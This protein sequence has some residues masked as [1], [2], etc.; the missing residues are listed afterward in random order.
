MLNMFVCQ[1][2]R[3][4]SV[5][6]S[7][8]FQ[9]PFVFFYGFLCAVFCLYGM[10]SGHFYIMK[11]IREYMVEHSASR[12]PVHDLMK[13]AVESYHLCTLRFLYM[14]FGQKDHF[15]Q[16]CQFFFFDIFRSFSCRQTFQSCPHMIDVFH[17]FPGDADYFGTSVRCDLHQTFQIQLPQGLP[18]RCPADT[19][20]FSQGR[21]FQF[22]AGCLVAGE[23]V[24]PDP[25]EDLAAQGLFLIF[26]SCLQIDSVLFRFI[27]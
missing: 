27:F 5:S 3:Q 6:L 26:H 12:R 13:S 14:K 24:V 10:G 22:F 7:D 2:F 8:R 1:L 21:F 9:D 20:L 4:I 17:I 15:F 11:K 25:V 16:F 18:Y 23:N 19:Q